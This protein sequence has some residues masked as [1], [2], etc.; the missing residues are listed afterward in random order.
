MIAIRTEHV[1]PPIPTRWHDWCAF[2]DGE[3]ELGQYGWGA[4]EQ[5]AINDLRDMYPREERS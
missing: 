3:E 5:E 1:Y 2:Y 4:T